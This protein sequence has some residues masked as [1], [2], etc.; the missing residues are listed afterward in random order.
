V[1]LAKAVRHVQVRIYQNR[2]SCERATFQVP[3]GPQSVLD[4][5]PIRQLYA[6]LTQ[7]ESLIKIALVDEVNEMDRI[8]SSK[9]SPPLATL[10]TGGTVDGHSR[11]GDVQ[12]ERELVIIEAVDG[13]HESPGARLRVSWDIG[14][15]R[16]ADDTPDLHTKFVAVHGSL[17]S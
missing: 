15:C 8:L 12:E 7:N 14:S 10:V 9:R 2:G 6:V 3:D 1:L 16:D 11:A 13:V 5:H 4:A 17:I